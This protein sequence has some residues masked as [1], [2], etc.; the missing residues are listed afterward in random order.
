M[1]TMGLDLD[2]AMGRVI[3]CLG[4]IGPGIGT[5]GPME[6]FAHIPDPGKWMLSF[7]M[8]LGRLELFTIMIIFT[9]VFWKR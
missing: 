5:V 6:N 9:P 2:S 4:T 3:A 8:L 7:L 1:T